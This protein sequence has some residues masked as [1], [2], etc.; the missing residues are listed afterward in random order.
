PASL[1]LAGNYANPADAERARHGAH[2][3][4][5]RRRMSSLCASSHQMGRRGLRAAGFEILC[6]G[7]VAKGLVGPVV[8]ISVGEGV[9]EELELIDAVWQVVCGVEFVSPGGLGAL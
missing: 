3:S 5:S 1:E 9:D 8:I 4:F 7:Q 6:G 2:P